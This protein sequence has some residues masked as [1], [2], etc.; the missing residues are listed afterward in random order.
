MGDE[1]DILSTEGKLADKK[2]QENQDSDNQHS[3]IQEIE[4]ECNDCKE[5]TDDDESSKEAKDRQREIED[6]LMEMDDFE[7]PGETEEETVEKD[8]ENN[9]DT[10]GDD[11][12]LVIEETIMNDNYTREP[13]K[14]E[15]LVKEIAKTNKEDQSKKKVQFF[16]EHNE[17]KQS[18]R[19]GPVQNSTAE[20]Q[21]KYNENKK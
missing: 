4:M 9:M 17:T 8:G 11:D 20:K 7:E 16:D 18:G 14:E 19:N 15:N 10:D 1:E 21:R 12:H 6:L 3:L 5:Y 13:E 2:D